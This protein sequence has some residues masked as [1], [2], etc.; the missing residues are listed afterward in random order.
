MKRQHT[1]ASFHFKGS[2]YFQ[3]TT[4]AP[5]T[6]KRILYFVVLAA[7]IV[8]SYRLYSSR[9]YPALNS[10]DALNILM[11]HCYRLPENIYC[12]GQDRGGTLIP[13]L[14]QPFIAL[15]CQ[16]VDAVSLA[17]YIILIL[18]F[19]GFSS[20]IKS[21]YCRILFAIVWFLP[22]QRFVD[23]N[24]FPLGVEYSLIG[25]AIWLITK[26]EKATK[27]FTRNALLLSIVVVLIA[28]VWVSDMA[29][30]TIVLLMMVLLVYDWFEKKKLTINKLGFGYAVAG[31]ALCGWF[32]SFAKNHAPVKKANY[33]DLN[34]LEG[35][36]AFF[37]S[38]G[39]SISSILTFGRGDYIVGIYTWLALAFIAFLIVYLIK[40]KKFKSLLKNRWF[41][42][43]GLDFLAVMA[44]LSMASWVQYNGVGRW[45][46]V[47]TYITLSMTVLIALDN[48]ADLSKWLKSSALIIALV[49]A[50]SPIYSMK[51]V[52][53]LTMQPRYELASELRQLGKAGIIAEYWNAYI[54]MCAAPDSIAAT[55]RENNSPRNMQLVDDVFANERIYVIRDMWLDSFPD[56]MEQFGRVLIK[57][58]DEFRIA[59]SNMCRYSVE[60]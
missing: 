14:S 50:V 35:V 48:S 13:L 34:N 39:E 37:R 15:G 8:A 59:G 44:V 29:I 28:S 10:D 33:L 12:W 57:S 22:S 53:P 24:R 9:F 27:A 7:I 21:P 20:L 55:P 30:V 23:I 45:Y 11:A 17:N 4:F 26:Y 31:T 47:P 41:V 6:K 2:G 38:L 46:F 51:N 32:I 49:G 52:F 42:F 3:F 60:E 56:R 40:N 1:P 58:G 18:G 5:M 19:L 36:G 43:F 54:N 25:F 16:P